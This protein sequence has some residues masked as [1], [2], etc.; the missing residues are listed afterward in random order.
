MTSFGNPVSRIRFYSKV[1]R[2]SQEGA[3]TADH[4]RCEFT[5]G[6]GPCGLWVSS[7]SY[8]LSREFLTITQETYL[9]ST[10]REVKKFI[11]LVSEILG[12]V[13]ATSV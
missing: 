2:I 8:E 9:D 6:L 5:T 1:P 11:Y 12:R 7:L 3:L 4:E 10:K 13:E